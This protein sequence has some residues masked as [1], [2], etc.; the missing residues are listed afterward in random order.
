M[1]RLERTELVFQG[2]VTIEK[3]GQKATLLFREKHKG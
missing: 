3:E 1:H 2:K